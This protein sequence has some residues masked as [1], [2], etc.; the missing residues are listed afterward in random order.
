MERDIIATIFFS[1]INGHFSYFHVLPTI[2]EVLFYLQTGDFISF[3]YIPRR[4]IL[5]S[6]ESSLFHF[7]RKV[8]NPY[9]DG[10]TKLPF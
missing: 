10:S 5:G 2:V 4:R 3:G 9:H 8:H 1:S 7:H 6:S